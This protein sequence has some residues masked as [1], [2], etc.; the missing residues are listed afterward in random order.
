MYSRSAF[1]SHARRNVGDGVAS[2]CVY[3][4]PTITQST[5]SKQVA[6]GSPGAMFKR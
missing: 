6:M 1:S 5:K 3:S 2:H 4:Q